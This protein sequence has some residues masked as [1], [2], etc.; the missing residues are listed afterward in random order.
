MALSASQ[1]AAAL[2]QSRAVSTKI[3]GLMEGYHLDRTC[4]FASLRDA[5]RR[6]QPRLTDLAEE[7]LQNVEQVNRLSPGARLESASARHG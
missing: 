2:E 7:L 4:A 3:A 1:L 6:Q 5:A